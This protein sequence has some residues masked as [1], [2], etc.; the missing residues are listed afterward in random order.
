[1]TQQEF[2]TRYTY[3]PATD[4]LGEGGFGKVFK[5]YDNYLDKWV[6]MKIAPIGVHE[7]VR[8]KKEVEMVKKLPAHPNI[9]RY[10]ECYTFSQLDGEYDFGILQYYEEGNLGK[11]LISNALTL[12]QKQ[13]LITQ[14]LD[15]L[16]FL[17]QNGI[18]HRD[19]KPQNILIV[20]RGAKYIPKITDFGISKQLDINKSSIF[21][22]SLAGA[23][24]L[25]YASPEQL[26]ESEI[27]KNTDLWSFGVIAYQTFTGTLPFTTGEH[28]STSEAGRM[29]LFR[30]INSGRLPG[31]IEQIAQPWQKVIR[32]CLVIDTELRV[33]NTQETYS[34]LN[35][36]NTPV[37]D[38]ETIID[39]PPPPS[40]PTP[41]PSRPSPSPV[42]RPKPPPR[43]TKIKEEWIA[44]GIIAAIALAVILFFALKPSGKPANDTPIAP[45]VE[46]VKVTDVTISPSGTVKIEVGKT[47]I[48]TATVVPSDAS[49]KNIS[50]S[51]LNTNIATVNT[52]GVVTGKSAGTAT[53]HAMAADGSGASSTKNITVTN[54]P[55]A[56]VK[57]TSLTINPS[58]TISIEAGKTTTL[59]V[60]VAPTNATNKSVTWSSL[61]ES[62]A[63]VNSQGMVTGKNTG[64]ATIRATA[65]DGSGITVTKSVTITQPVSVQTTRVVEP[66]LVFVQGGTFTM[67]GTSEQGSD[68]YDNEKP[69]H[70][71]TLSSYYIGKYPVTQKEWISVMG[72]NPSNFKGDNLPVEGVSWDDVQE[73]IRK[74]NAATG[75][76]YRLPTESE[77][78]YAA[79]GGSRSGN[80]KY[81]GSNNV[82]DV[83]WYD[84]NSGRKTQPVGTKAGNE[85]GIHDM[86]GNVWEWCSDWYGSYTSA[87]KTNPTGPSTG[88]SRVNRGGFFINYATYV[89][90]SYRLFSTPDYRNSFIGFRLASS[91]N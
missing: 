29:E 63:T 73:F 90:V 25:A 32:C 22:N 14:I 33:K 62:I 7:S 27:R 6:A 1:M 35:R 44:G 52:Q 42:P 40:K 2:Q 79:R 21:N 86:S 12:E 78:E 18:I 54:P 47:A 61:H 38:D 89:R 37:V 85:L 24:T 41:V 26:R 57:V 8:L 82:N 71:V 88:S 39:A 67:G 51:S 55:P 17:H 83:A 23:G 13:S 19:L 80:F 64:T 28:A 30:Q 53:I 31:A 48:L 66:Q 49:N 77:W 69:T 65:A 76:K 45:P 10:E 56:E 43:Q 60:I 4:K 81:S 11:L 59:T 58:G 72:S 84:R 91:S 68:A 5:A 50:W 46:V 15:G 3:N 9:A 70:Q 74:L 36:V 75:K 16:D 34:I 20:K 87:S